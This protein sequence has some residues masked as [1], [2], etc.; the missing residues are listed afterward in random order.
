MAILDDLR[1]ASEADR[2]VLLVG[3][4]EDQV[5]EMLEWPAS[6]RVEL[7]RGFA[8]IG[9]DSMMSVDLQFRVQSS[10]DFAAPSADDFLQPSVEALA[11]R[12]LDAQ[13]LPLDD[14][15]AASPPVQQMS[16]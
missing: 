7:A 3:F 6:R 4:I 15:L 11:Q 9:F 16:S 2:Y 13:L 1:A 14:P 5:M 8:A 12:L 10:L